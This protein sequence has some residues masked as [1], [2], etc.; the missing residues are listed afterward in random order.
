LRTSS[1][2]NLSHTRRS[3]SS[4][5]CSRS[6]LKRLAKSTRIPIAVYMREAVGDLLKLYAKE[7]RKAGK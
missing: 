2:Q 4:S 1:A 5:R 6:T 3:S 7:L